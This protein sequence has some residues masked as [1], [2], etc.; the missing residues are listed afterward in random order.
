MRANLGQSS[1]T[2]KKAATSRAWPVAFARTALVAIAL[3]A[4]TSGRRSTVPSAATHRRVA[5]TTLTS[6]TAGVPP[7]TAGPAV[8]LPA[9]VPPPTTR[10]LLDVGP[11]QVGRPWGKKVDGLLTF[12]GN[13]SRTFYG[14]GPMPRTA[15]KILWRFPE[16][17]AL[18]SVSS[19]QHGERQWCGT[20]WT[21]EPAVFERNGRTWMA[22]G[23][24]GSAVHVLDADTGKRMLPDL[25]VGDIIKGG[26]TVDPDGF[27]L[28]YAGPRDNK[29]RVIAIDRDVPTVLW[30]LSANAVSPTKWNNDWDGSPL[31]VD[32]Y[33][34]EG[35][36]NSQFHVVKL[37][38][39][40]DS[41]GKVTVDPQLV[42][43]TPGWDD[44]LVRQVGQ[45][46][47]IE[48]SVAMSGSVAYFANSG[49]LVQGWDLSPIP[50]GQ[51]AV[52]TFRFW[53][54]DDTDASVVI[55]EDGMLYV[56]SEFERDNA[57]SKEVGQIMKLDPSKPDD[58][59]V[60]SIPARSTAPSGVWATPALAGD[61]VIVVTDDGDVLGLDRADGTIRWTFHLVPHLWSSPVVIDDVLLVGACD[62]RLHAYD[63]AADVA[64]GTPPPALWDVRIDGGCIESTPAVWN[65]RIYVGT[66]AGAVYALG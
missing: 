22:F 44:Q 65:G 18:C 39:G 37:N 36:E 57:R 58:P 61:L 28:F 43:H 19:D 15:P 3:V 5:S 51:P 27:P 40:Y 6:S 38:R 21:G 11:A 13:P 14:T 2:D 12:R 63:L 46:V 53:T 31:I 8:P 34:I 54:G 56:A 1:R 52:R 66:R 59:I 33:L 16:T 45:D 50:R 25:K 42:F 49:G 4:C 20:G 17:G 32:D 55:D 24:Y 64:N 10:P 7:S 62:G 47:S 29:L 26:V 60:W 23:S 48:N 41:D 35:G 30:E 9:V